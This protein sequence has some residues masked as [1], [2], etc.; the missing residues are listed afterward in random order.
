[1][2][3]DGVHRTSDDT[4]VVLHSRRRVLDEDVAGIGVI[5]SSGFEVIVM[6]LS[7]GKVGPAPRRAACGCPDPEPAADIPVRVLTAGSWRTH[8]QNVD[9]RLAVWQP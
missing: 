5:V 6:L 2:R 3:A 9:N 8:R 4:H 1:M 7:P